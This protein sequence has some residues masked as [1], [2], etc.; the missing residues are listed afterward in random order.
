MWLIWLY[1]VESTTQKETV[2]GPQCQTA[3][4]NLLIIVNNTGCSGSN[5]HILNRFY[6]RLNG[7]LGYSLVP[8]MFTTLW[9]F[10]F[11]LTFPKKVQRGAQIELLKNT[12]NF[13]KFFHFFCSKIPFYVILKQNK[14]LKKFQKNSF[15]FRCKG[16]PLWTK[17]FFF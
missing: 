16:S 13:K 6:G 11:Y 14:R 2:Q 3:K 12:K 17:K 5:W 4:S 10:V 1:L 7:F 8:I 15:F 9:H